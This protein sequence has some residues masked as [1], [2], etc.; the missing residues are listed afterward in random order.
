MNYPKKINIFEW[1]RWGISITLIRNI[2]YLNN[3]KAIVDVP[4]HFHFNIGNLANMFAKGIS[5]GIAFL[6]KNMK[7][8]DKFSGISITIPLRRGNIHA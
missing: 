7:E 5:F 6:N 1:Y 4:F 2:R 3:K 8:T